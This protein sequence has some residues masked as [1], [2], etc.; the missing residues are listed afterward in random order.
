MSHTFS[1]SD[2]F[3]RN[4]GWL[5][6]QEQQILRHKRIAIA[7]LGGVGGSHLLTLVRLGISN[8]HIADFDVFDVVNFNRQAGASMSSLGKSKVEVMRDLAKDINPELNIRVFPEGTHPTNLSEF[9]TDIDL[10]IDGLDFFAFSAREAAFAVCADQGIPAITVAPLGMGAALLN[11]MPRKMTFEEYFRL[12]DVP[13]PDKAVHFLLGLSPAMLQRAYLADPS[14]VDL[15]R[16]RGPSTAMAC[17]LCAGIAATEAL[18]ILLKR[19]KVHAA[20]HGLHF[21]AYRNKLVH[22]WR[23]WGNNNPLQRLLIRIARAQLARMARVTVTDTPHANV[24]EQILDLARWAPSGDNTQPWR[25]EIIH[26]AHIV[27]HGFDTREHCVYDINGRPSHLAIGALLENIAIAA[28]THGLR[29]NIEYRKNSPDDTPLFDV[30]LVSDPQTRADPLAPY[31]RTRSVQRRPL[32]SRPL[33][34]REKHALASSVGE[35]YHILWLEGWDKKWQMAKLLFRNAKLRLTMPEAYAV[36]SQ[37]IEYRARYSQDRVPDQAVG[38]DPITTALM[39]WVMRSW[40]R[41]EF[42]NTFLAGTLLPRIQLD[43]IPALA[44][45]SHFVIVADQAAQTLPDYVAAGRAMQ[46]FWLTSTQLGLQLQPEMTPLIFATYIRTGTR[47]SNTPGMWEQAQELSE[48]LE[49]QIGKQTLSDA[50]FMG[51]IGAGNVPTARSTRL[52]L[53]HLMYKT[54]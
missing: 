37:V 5:T 21:D 50:V 45:A 32:Q 17:Q 7:G 40:G 13:E 29:A 9:F 52:P 31:I 41:V 20:P 33:T 6:P 36:H 1:Y 48:Q 12:Q 35:G 19:G 2:A 10:Y 11:F 47:F 26:P 38:L 24:T 27:V 34:K 51:R 43:L 8:F 3:S 25:F 23:P 39:R 53:T 44:C 46:R 49:R 18:K 22:T 54:T 16:Q 4:I 42:F 14:A 28:S 30:Y 15:S